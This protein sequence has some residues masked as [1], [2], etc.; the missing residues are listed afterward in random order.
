M[1]NSIIECLD[2][3]NVQYEIRKYERKQKFYK[4]LSLSQNSKYPKC[5]L[6][7]TCVNIWNGKI[8]RCPALMYINKFNEVFGTSLPNAG[9]I[10]LD[11]DICGKELLEALTKDVPLC[12]H[13]VSNLVDWSICGKTP[14]LEDFATND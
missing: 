9:I 11:S 13:C 10:D 6:S 2:G 7:S 14:K 5:C 8:A 12:K 4:P 3:N 1:I